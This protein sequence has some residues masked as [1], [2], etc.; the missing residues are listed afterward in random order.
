[1]ESR[2][3]PKLIDRGASSLQRLGV[4]SFVFGLRETTGAS[5][6]LALLVHGRLV[7][8]RALAAVTTVLLDASGAVAGVALLCIEAEPATA[9]AGVANAVYVRG[10]M[11]LEK[12]GTV[13][14]LNGGSIGALGV[15]VRTAPETLIEFAFFDHAAVLFR[16]CLSCGAEESGSVRKGL[17]LTAVVVFDDLLFVSPKVLLV[18]DG[19][20]ESEGG[21]DDGLEE[22]AAARS[23]HIVFWFWC[24]FR[25]LRLQ[26]KCAW[27]AYLV[28]RLEKYP[29]SH[30]GAGG[31]LWGVLEMGWEGVIGYDGIIV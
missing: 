3:A 7:V 31:S 26:G 10:H 29:Q 22:T 19:G 14:A 6:P 15:F 16:L 2:E 27:K 28:I 24:D 18:L 4:R 5:A 13:F 12:A 9:F 25:G 20:S 30:C 1:M 8:A 11:V 17:L 23:A 21:F